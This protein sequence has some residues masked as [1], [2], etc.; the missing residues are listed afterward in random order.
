MG[1][2]FLR[3]IKVAVMSGSGPDGYREL[4]RCKRRLRNSLWREP[5][6]HHIKTQIHDVRQV[7]TPAQRKKM[8]CSLQFNGRLYVKAGRTMNEVAYCIAQEIII[9]AAGCPLVNNKWFPLASCFFS[10]RKTGQL[11][12]ASLL[13]GCEYVLV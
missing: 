9:D 12:P 2:L 13:K 7:V 3:G 5:L 1:E 4:T 11:K 8:H 6:W 10:C